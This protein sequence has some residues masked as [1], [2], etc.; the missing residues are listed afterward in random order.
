MLCSSFV[1]LTMFSKENDLNF[2]K[3]VGNNLHPGANVVHVSLQVALPKCT[4][5]MYTDI[6]YIHTH[7]HMYACGHTCIHVCVCRCIMLAY[8]YVY[9]NMYTV[10]HLQVCLYTE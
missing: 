4:H 8:F 1:S 9:S 3:V 6:T 5:N 10:N 7:V 2:S